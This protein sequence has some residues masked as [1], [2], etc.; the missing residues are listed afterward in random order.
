[1]LRES[2]AQIKRSVLPKPETKIDPA[3]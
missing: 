3:P 1:L 2:L